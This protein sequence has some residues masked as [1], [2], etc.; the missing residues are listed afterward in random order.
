[1]DR[2]AKLEIEKILAAAHERGDLPVSIKNDRG[3]YVFANE[4]WSELAE[5]SIQEITSRRDDQLPW[6]AS[7]AKFIQHLDGET[8]RRGG[9]NISDRRPHFQTRVWMRTGIERVYVPS[10]HR[11]ICVVEPIARDDF[12]RWATSVTES[13]LAFNGVSLSIKQLYLL[14]QLLFHVPLKQ[15]AKELGCST[16]RIHQYLRV[17]RD[18]FEADDNKELVCALSA[19]GLFPLL[20]RF[21]LL[22]KHNWVP[23]ELKRH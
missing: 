9:L 1:M 16:T 2:E 10:E 23:D 5:A 3:V 22:F 20:E 12:C 7:N 19:Y 4:G 11:L 15:T 6:A 21:D 13:G 14:H 17:L 18:H 8:R